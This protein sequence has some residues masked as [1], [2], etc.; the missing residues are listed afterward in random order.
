MTELAP[1]VK[2]LHVEK[3]TGFYSALADALINTG[4]H[5]GQLNAIFAQKVRIQCVECGIELTADELSVWTLSP[6]EARLDNPKLERL[7]QG[8]CGRKDCPSRYFAVTL[9]PHPELNWSEVM[10]RVENP[11]PTETQ[12]PTAAGTSPSAPVS[13]GQHQSPWTKSR[14]RL[15]VGVIVLLGLLLCRYLMSDSPF[16]GFKSKPKYTVDPAS[17]NQDAR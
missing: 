9:S 2:N 4:L 17:L 14:I 5:S 7:R 15:L 1:I 8:Y 16:P 13:A 6:A 12:S 3:L 10:A 11:E